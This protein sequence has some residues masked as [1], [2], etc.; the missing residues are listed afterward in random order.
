MF[1]LR[2]IASELRRRRGR[3]ILTALGLGV[4]VGLVVTVTALSAGLDDAQSQVLEP[5]TGVGTEMTVNRPVQIGDSGT[6]GIGGP[7]QL[8]EKERKRLEKEGAGPPQIDFSA[9][10]NPG[11][12][13]STDQFVTTDLSFPASEVKRI[14]ATDGVDAVSPALTL[15]LI[16]IEGTI[17]DTSGTSAQTFGPAGGAA[18]Q[19][20][21]PPG[22]GGFGV[23]PT[24]VTGIDASQTDLGLVKAEQVS[25]GRFLRSGDRNSALLTQT[26]ADENGISVGDRVTVGK[27]KLDVVGLVKAPL[28]GDASDI[29]MPLSTLQKLSDR[30]GRVNALEVRAAN[31]DSVDTVSK[32]VESEFAGSQVTTA[33]DLS[34]RVSGSLVDARNLS[35]K[36]GTALA[37]VAL[38]AAFLIAS[39]L[40]LASVNKR[41][42]ELGTLKAIG[43]RQWRVVRQVSGESVAQ[44]LIGGA[45]GALIGLG[46]AALVGALGISLKASAGTQ[47]AAGPVFG[48]PGAQVTSG[49]STV[50]LGAPVDAQLLLLAIGLAVLGGLIAGAVGGIRAGRLR[51]AEALRSV[52]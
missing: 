5:L 26:Y 27:R 12:K 34:D 46:G 22:G 17:P 15:S 2:Y 38:A 29:Y 8:S 48:P 14:A 49:S 16:H 35:D 33:K 40:S 50:T 30:Q 52:E 45:A 19:G 10:G 4:G 39:L 36:L 20:G 18:T 43:W 7:Q 9:L 51:P 24:T 1:Y 28:G 3:T 32:R 44:G 6:P 21:G 31:V 42:R 11:D 41:T 37:V 23:A 25:D 13:F 47:V